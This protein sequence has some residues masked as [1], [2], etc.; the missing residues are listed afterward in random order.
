MQIA[1]RYNPTKALHAIAYT[2]GKIGSTD[3][4][5]LMKLLYLADKQHFIEHG[6]PITGDRLCAMPYGPVPSGTL[7]LVNGVPLLPSSDVFA[8]IHLNDNQVSLRQEPADSQLST[9]ERRT[10]DAVVAAYA[11]LSPWALVRMTHHLPEYTEAYVE[12]SSRTIAYESIARH[13]ASEARYRHDRPVISPET[14]ARIACPFSPADAD[15]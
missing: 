3:K 1:F 11:H 4:V 12:G 14:A 13:S 9:A 15:L 8:A 7:D 10:L 5:K 6:Y 2:L